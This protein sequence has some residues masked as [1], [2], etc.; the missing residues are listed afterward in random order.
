MPCAASRIRKILLHSTGRIH[1]EVATFLPKSEYGK[2]FWEARLHLFIYAS[3]IAMSIYWQTWLPLMFIGV[4][5]LVGSWLMPVYGLTQHAGMAENVLDHRVNCRTVEMN[6]LNRFLYWNMNYHIEHHMFPLV[7]YHALPRLHELMKDDCPPVYPGIFSAYKEIIPAIRKQVKDPTYHVVRDL[8]TPSKSR[9][10]PEHTTLRFAGSADKTNSKGI[11]EVCS[12]DALPKGEVLRFDY[13]DRTYAIYH[14]DKGKFYATDGICTHGSAH[15]ADGFGDGNQIECPKHTGRFCITDGSAKRD[16]VCVALKTY[17][18]E[19]ED[20]KLFIDCHSAGGQGLDVGKPVSFRVVS[21]KN[22]ASYIKE[23]VLEPQDGSFLF[24]PGQHLQLEIPPYSACSFEGLQIDK[25][26][27][28]IWK[29][30]NL[31]QYHA[32]NGV[33]T[34]RNFSFASNPDTEKQ[35]RFNVRIEFPPPGLNCSA[36]VG[37]TYV[38]G[39]NSGDTV[40]AVGPFGNFHIRESDKEMIYVG[41]GAGMAPLRSHLSYLFETQKTTRKVSFWYGARSL[42][43]LFYDDYFKQLADD[44][45]NFSFHVAL[46]EPLPQDNWNSHTGFI[47]EVLDAEYLSTISHQSDIE[48]LPLRSTRAHRSN[49][50][51]PVAL[52][53]TRRP[54]RLRR[55]LRNSIF[56]YCC[57]KRWC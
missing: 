30:Q 36:G 39:L 50:E 5:T 34:R 38:F 45:E 20:G 33:L 9:S 3:V 28:Q 47:H 23:L 22:V 42:Q 10:D 49:E 17:P 24:K 57:G 13:A 6:W 21:N 31:H 8:P 4:S 48:Y 41:G 16:P 15:L 29:E 46:S 51:S 55:I 19:E 12:I 37:S 35:L 40:N 43:E 52:R 14:T 25:P 27:S 18:I 1:P 2:V 56:R 44:H 54:D 53:H 32:T 26:Y 7:P 11:L